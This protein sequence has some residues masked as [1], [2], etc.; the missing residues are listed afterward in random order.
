MKSLIVL[1]TII[2][3]AAVAGSIVVGVRSFDGIVTEHPYEK[4]LLWDEIQNRKDELGWTV[5]IGDTD[6]ITGGND[7]EISLINKDGKPVPGSSVSVMISRPSTTEY[8]KHF[9]TVRG[10]EG[11]FISTL[12][13]PLFGY[14]NVG[15]NVTTA[16]ETLLFE[17]RIYVKKGENT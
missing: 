10:R 4:G 1:V 15:I 2:G 6:L 7:V 14:W 16:G 11:V 9:D 13:F 8:D 12:T 3:A 5:E 17:K